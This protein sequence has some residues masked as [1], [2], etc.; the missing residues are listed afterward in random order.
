[1]TQHAMNQSSSPLQIVPSVPVAILLRRGNSVTSLRE[2][3]TRA[4][5]KDSV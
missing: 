1:V 2:E 5:R 3:R 4:R